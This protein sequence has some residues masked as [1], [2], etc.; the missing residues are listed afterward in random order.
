M[1]HNNVETFEVKDLE[2]LI[3]QATFDLEEVDKLRRDEFKQ[4]ELEKEFERR[5]KLEVN[6]RFEFKIKFSKFC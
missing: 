6:E 5:K 2:S 3:K 1:D 4:H